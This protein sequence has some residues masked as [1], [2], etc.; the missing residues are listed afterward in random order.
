[1][2]FRGTKAAGSFDCTRA[3]SFELLV[4]MEAD[5]NSQS[6]AEFDFATALPSSE[7]H[8]FTELPAY[9]LRHRAGLFVVTIDP[10]LN[11]RSFRYRGFWRELDAI[12][13]RRGIWLLSSTRA[14]LRRQPH[15]NT[16]LELARC[17][18][19]EID[20][21]D[22]ERVID[23]LTAFGPA[24][25]LECA[26]LC[27]ASADSYDAILRLVSS[28]VV[29]PSQPDHLTPSTGLRLDPPETSSIAWL[30]GTVQPLEWLDN[31]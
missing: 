12:L 7:V 9:L 28:G 24:S 20:P 15:W 17:A 27:T 31:P 30:A 29:F 10:E 11:L 3:G 16:A 18:K 6:Y 5:P 21:R 8:Q 1:M 2:K 14:E 26:R 25:L 13:A 4:H 19:A 22:Q 23:Y